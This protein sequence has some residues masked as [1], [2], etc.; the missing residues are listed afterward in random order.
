MIK[1]LCQD[2]FLVYLLTIQQYIIGSP[3][4]L[5][6]MEGLN[7]SSSNDCFFF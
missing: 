2:S 4:F 1:K 3:L 7:F 6:K 5:L